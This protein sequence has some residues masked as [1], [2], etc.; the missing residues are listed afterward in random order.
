MLFLPY[1]YEM[2]KSKIGF[3][4]PYQQA[5][6]GPKPKTQTQFL[7]EVEQLLFNSEYY[8]QE[9]E[10][11]NDWLNSVQVNQAKQNAHLIF[12]LMKS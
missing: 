12:Q 3:T 5:T 6:P 4:I 2:Y 10:D 1:D 8:A 11:A 7:Q 9:R